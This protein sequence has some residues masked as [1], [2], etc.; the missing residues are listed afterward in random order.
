M[1]NPKVVTRFFFGIVLVGLAVAAGVAIYSGDIWS[2]TSPL[3]LWAVAL[4][5]F[6]LFSIGNVLVFGPLI[7]VFKALGHKSAKDGGE[8]KQNTG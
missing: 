2:P 1:E 3:A 6:A 4:S 5:V 8:S 7:L